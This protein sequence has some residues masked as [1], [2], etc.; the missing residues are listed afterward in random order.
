MCVDTEA[1]GLSE[2]W[3]VHHLPSLRL[4][5][6]EHNVMKKK[7]KDFEWNSRI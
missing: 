2:V 4:S 1:K 3:V 5:Y 6:K 7:K